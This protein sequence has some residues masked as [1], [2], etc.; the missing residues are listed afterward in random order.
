MKPIVHAATFALALAAVGIAADSRAADVVSPTPMPGIQLNPT[1]NATIAL[2][3]TGSG[4]R[5]IES[6]APAA[7]EW[8]VR[9]NGWQQPYANSKVASL[10]FADAADR[11]KTEAACG[12]VV[13]N[14]IFYT[15][16][17]NDNTWHVGKSQATY[18]AL[19]DKT[20]LLCMPQASY[21]VAYDHNIDAVVVRGGLAVAGAKKKVAVRGYMY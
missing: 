13:F 4:Q 7:E 11:P 2:P 15:H 3:N 16:T 10:D 5:Q 19:W 18:K 20:Q 21:S 12:E 9:I 1:A 17:A 6:T 8:A 14:A